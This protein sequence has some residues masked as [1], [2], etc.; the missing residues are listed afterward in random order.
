MHLNEPE[1]PHPADDPTLEPGSRL[2]PAKRVVRVDVEKPENPGKPKSHLAV[3]PPMS[4][5]T[6]EDAPQA[7]QEV[8]PM[9]EPTQAPSRPAEANVEPLTEDELTTALETETNEVKRDMLAMQLRLLRRGKLREGADE[10]AERDR[11]QREVDAKAAEEKAAKARQE[12]I[13]RRPMPFGE[14]RRAVGE[15]GIPGKIDA[16]RYR[17]WVPMGVLREVVA[18]I[19]QQQARNPE[20]SLNAGLVLYRCQGIVA[21][22]RQTLDEP[23]FDPEAAAVASAVA[24]GLRV[25][26]DV[27][28]ERRTA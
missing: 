7:S 21:Q 11:Q 25:S 18:A 13:D 10:G 2:K 9:P 16:T 19:R 28:K 15:M 27:A 8:A 4:H 23:V 5:Q 22:Q 3:V 26:Y 24:S 6:R 17:F 14:F 20:V 1:P 12:A